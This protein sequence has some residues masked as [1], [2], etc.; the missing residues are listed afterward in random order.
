MGNRP[1]VME[2]ALVRVPC[3]L[4][5]KGQMLAE[6]EQCRYSSSAKLAGGTLQQPMIAERPPCG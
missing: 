5:A 3:S 4:A 1:R 6:L 2:S